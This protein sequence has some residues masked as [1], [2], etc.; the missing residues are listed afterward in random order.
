MGVT[1]KVRGER[2][3]WWTDKTTG[4]NSSLAQMTG[5]QSHRSFFMGRLLCKRGINIYIDTH[6]EQLKT[7]DTE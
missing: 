1:V 7:P 2:D 4:P 3:L 5:L 6:D